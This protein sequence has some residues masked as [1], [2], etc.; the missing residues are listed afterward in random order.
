MANLNL[1]R[2]RSISCIDQNI[3]IPLRKICSNLLEE[4]PAPK[5][6]LLLDMIH[7]VSREVVLQFKDHSILTA[8]HNSYCL[9]AESMEDLLL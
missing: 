2:C 6:T 9:S 5:S 4:Q 3:K 7:C 8:K 1:L